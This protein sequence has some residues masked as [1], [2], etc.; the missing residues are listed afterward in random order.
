M[1][2]ITSDDGGWL[3][4]V[5]KM[6]HIKGTIN[7][8]P[9]CYMLYLD[10]GAHVYLYEYN[11]APRMWRKLRPDFVGANHGDDLFTVFGLCSQLHML[12]L[13]VCEEDIGKRVMKYWANIARPGSPNGD[14]LVHWPEYGQEESYL[15]IDTEQV[16]RQQ[17]MQE[18]LVFMTQI[19]PKMVKKIEK[20]EHME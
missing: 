18:R 20:K 3:L 12:K 6:C 15:F 19:L 8:S 5:V 2:G 17:P 14:G 16:V 11:F 13:L 1:T 9:G 10:A 4:S 7:L